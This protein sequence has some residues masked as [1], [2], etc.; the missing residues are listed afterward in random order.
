ARGDPSSGRCCGA[1]RGGGG[2]DRRRGRGGGGGAEGKNSRRSAPKTHG[3]LGRCAPR[4]G[5]G[6]RGRG[7]GRS[8]LFGAERPRT[9]TVRRSFPAAPRSRRSPAAWRRTPASTSRV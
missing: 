8:L 1:G 4:G 2:G 9:I 5:G 3:R 6:P 7:S